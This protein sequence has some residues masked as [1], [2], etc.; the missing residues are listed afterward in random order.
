ML[1]TSEDIESRGDGAAEPA[2]KEP[3]ATARLQST[4][5]ARVTVN[6]R[7]GWQKLSGCN[8][9][10][11]AGAS[12]KQPGSSLVSRESTSGDEVMGDSVWQFLA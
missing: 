6:L 2:A 7:I 11:S 9:S 8:A 12:G 5:T 1:N 10:E 4:S 3:P